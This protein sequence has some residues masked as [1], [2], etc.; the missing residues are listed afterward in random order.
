MTGIGITGAMATTWLAFAINAGLVLLLLG[1]L[2]TL[3]RAVRGPL[4][5]DRLVALVHSWLIGIGL[6]ILLALRSHSWRSLDLALALALLGGIVPLA[7]SW[8]NRNAARERQDNS[9]GEVTHVDAH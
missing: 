8:A 1:A 6:I 2:L 5:S 3:W 9:N 4:R 7:W